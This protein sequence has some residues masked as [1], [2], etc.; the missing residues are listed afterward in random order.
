MP[1][2]FGM[3]CLGPLLFPL[4]LSNIGFCTLLQSLLR[5]ESFLLA[6]GLS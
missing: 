2:A 1:L 5:I 6:S 3:M 4:D